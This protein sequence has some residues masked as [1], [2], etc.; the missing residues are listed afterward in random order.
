MRLREDDVWQSAAAVNAI[1]REQQRTRGKGRTEC[2][3]KG[4]SEIKMNFQSNVILC[5]GAAYNKSK[6]IIVYHN[7]FN[8]SS[9][10]SFGSYNGSDAILFSCN[11]S[12]ARTATVWRKH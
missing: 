12:T 6:K 7:F 8:A 3:S 10:D 2:V 4:H 11:V 9:V 5:Y 1:K